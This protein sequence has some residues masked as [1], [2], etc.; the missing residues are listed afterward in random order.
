MNIVLKKEYGIVD[1]IEL[2]ALRE[3]KRSHCRF[4]ECSNG[5]VYLST[6]QKG[7][8]TDANSY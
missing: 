3:K 1:G 7:T 8:Y 4:F 6:I 2:N 5:H